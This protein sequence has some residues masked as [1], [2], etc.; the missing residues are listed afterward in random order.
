MK[1][2]EIVGLSLTWL[3]RLFLLITGIAYLISG[4]A[5][6][7]IIYIFIFIL[8][9]LF[10]ML[11]QLYKVKFHWL[12][13]LVWTFM[14]SVHMFG[15]LGAY[16]WIPFYDDIAHVLGSAILAF[17]GFVMIYAMNY[18]GKI[19]VNLPI[20][21]MFTFIWT[22]AIGAVWEILE[23]IWD[24]IVVLSYDYGFAQN[25]L[26]DTMSD[27]S[28][29]ATAGVC[30]A[31]FCVFFIKQIEKKQIKGFFEPFAKIVQRK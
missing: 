13:N 6:G 27:I 15:F 31:L 21:G 5:I 14:L 3:F 7:F 8:S 25:S 1:I 29:D 17:M 28:L 12:A 16:I 9:L 19:R 20:M 24:N 11:G 2:V 4:D 10:I 22:L 23:F 26:F 18:A 30:V